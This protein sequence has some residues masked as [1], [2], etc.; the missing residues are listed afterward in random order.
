[1]IEVVAVK[2]RLPFESVPGTPVTEIVGG[3]ALKNWS[4]PVIG[5]VL[6]APVTVAV[7]VTLCPKFTVPRF[8]VSTPE[9]TYTTEIPVED[10][11]AGP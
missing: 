3:G 9:V 11:L 2:V 7:T 10:E 1:M 5:G 8:A 4:V 6:L